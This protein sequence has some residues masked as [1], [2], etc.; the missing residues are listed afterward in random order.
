MSST[1]SSNTINR[2]ERQ[3]DFVGVPEARRKKELSELKRRNETKTSS[4]ERGLL[5]LTRNSGERGMKGLLGK[6]Y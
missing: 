6:K 2:G 5:F 3:A 4:G 1:R